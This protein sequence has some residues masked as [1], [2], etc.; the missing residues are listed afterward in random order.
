[1]DHATN[2]PA[3][4]EQTT[5]ASVNRRHTTGNVLSTIRLLSWKQQHYDR[6]RQPLVW[7]REGAGVF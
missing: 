4:Y 6:L 3:G 7:K 5:T 1:M 2:Y